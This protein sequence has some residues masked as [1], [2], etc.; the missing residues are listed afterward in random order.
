MKRD[1]QLVLWHPCRICGRPM[2]PD[3]FDFDVIVGHK[4]CAW[5]ALR[6]DPNVPA[7]IW[8]DARSVAR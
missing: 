4:A 3:P 8:D 7:E 6:W 5:A 1:P 2:L